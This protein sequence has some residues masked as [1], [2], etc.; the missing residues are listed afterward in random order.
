MGQHGG[1][2]ARAQGEGSEGE[3]DFIST[4]IRV[5]QESA[6]CCVNYGFAVFATDY[7][8]CFYLTQLDHIRQ[9]YHAVDETQAGVGDIENGGCG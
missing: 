1:N 9:G 8:S 5:S 4:S 2:C 3:F 7:N 6:D